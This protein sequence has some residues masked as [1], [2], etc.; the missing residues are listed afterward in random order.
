MT[1]RL[2]L[3]LLLLALLLL[4]GLFRRLGV[5]ELAIIVA[6]L[7]IAFASE[8]IRFVVGQVVRGMNASREQ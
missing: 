3:S 8:S 1:R 6:F 5:G 2:L 4:T 7:V